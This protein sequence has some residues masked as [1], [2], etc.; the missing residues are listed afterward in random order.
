M[1]TRMTIKWGTIGPSAKMKSLN[2]PG[3]HTNEVHVEAL[4][5]KRPITKVPIPASL[6]CGPHFPHRRH[7]KTLPNS[8]KKRKKKSHFFS[9]SQ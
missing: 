6:P 8:S 3:A 9:V 5:P 4:P 7:F 2:R 1:T